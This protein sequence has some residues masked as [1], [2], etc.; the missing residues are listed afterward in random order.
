MPF[1]LCWLHIRDNFYSDREKIVVGFR[2]SAVSLFIAKRC[3]CLQTSCHFP[4]KL[5][6][7]SVSSQSNWKATKRYSTHIVAD[8]TQQVLA[9]QLGNTYFVLLSGGCHGNPDPS[10]GLCNWAL[11]CDKTE[12]NDQ[13]PRGWCYMK[14]DGNREPVLFKNQFLVVE[15]LG[16]IDSCT[17]T[18]FS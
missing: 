16:L 1:E 3:K 2:H 17:C 14:R 12:N 6:W 8:F 5:L 10:L 13:D 18:T 7:Q 15:S 9:N 11:I 4:C